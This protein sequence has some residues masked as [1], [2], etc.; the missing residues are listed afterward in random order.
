MAGLAATMK[1]VL[2]R[3]ETKNNLHSDWLKGKQPVVFGDKLLDDKKIPEDFSQLDHFNSELNYEKQV[4]KSC[5]HCHQ[6][7]DAQR[8]ELRAAGKKFPDE[9]LY[10]FPAPS[11]IGI[12]FD[13]K[14]ATTIKHIETGSA[15][16]KAGLQ[17]GDQ[18][19][20]ANGQEI[21]SA[22]DFVWVLHGLKDQPELRLRVVRDEPRTIVIKLEQDWRKAADISW[23]VTTWEMRRMATGGATFE[24]VDE[25]LRKRRGI[26][27][28][29]MALRVGHVGQYGQHA[30]A[31]Q[32]GVRKNDLLVGVDD[33]TDLLTEAAILEYAIQEKQPGDELTFHLL[34]NGRTL[35][36]TIRLQ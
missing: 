13:P 3:H 2:R 7:R 36:A 12:T 30:R 34:R 22:A 9:L 24:P 23:R 5:I 11:T 27:D 29:Q 19:D 6:I 16:D 4:A 8:F 32:A 31:K 14:T 28:D 20:L 35:K 33:R 10:P 1:R 18:I 15:A 17:V 25:Q 26:R 21:M